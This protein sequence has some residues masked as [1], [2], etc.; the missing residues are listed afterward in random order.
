MERVRA[1][2][3][4]RGV[5]LAITLFALGTGCSGR[6]PVLPGDG[7]SGSPGP[8]APPDAWGQLAA[9]VAAAQD[10]RYVAGYT[11]THSGQP[12]RT[13]TVTV[14]QDGSWL[15]SIPGGVLGG[16]ADVTVADSRTGLYQCAT[17]TSPGCVR[18]AGPDGQLP[19]AVDP[20]LEHV[21]TDW[22][23]VLADRQVAISVDTAK[24]LP[25]AR[26]Q[27]FSVEPSSASLVAPVDAGVYCYDTDG[28]L[29]AANL[30]LG[31]LMLTGTP[32]P[33]PP[34]AALP[35][36]IVPRAALPT[37]APPP[38]SPSAVPSKA[39]AAPAKPSAVP[40]R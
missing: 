19:A 2:T 28:T 36:P 24:P 32:A 7:P 12:P 33:A 6:P 29:T 18:V 38:A 40:S 21:F 20:R 25:G 8:A 35:A 23:V 27:C 37:A 14:A 4:V 17:G 5:V 3:T 16:T 13:V 1:Q 30:S 26:G 11:L 22:L 15:V 31:T 9:R 10:K 34:T 39:S